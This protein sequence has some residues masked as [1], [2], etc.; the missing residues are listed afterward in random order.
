MGRVRLGC[1]HAVSGD[2]TIMPRFF[3]GHGT[4]IPLE[5]SLWGRL[6]SLIASNI[7]GSFGLRTFTD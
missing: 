1:L 4:G 6:R 2:L 3:I 7:I 5:Y